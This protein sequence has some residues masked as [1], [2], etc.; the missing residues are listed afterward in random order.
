MDDDEGALRWASDD[1]LVFYSED[2][3]WGRL[4]A[5]RAT[6]GTP[7]PLTPANCMVA[8]SEAARNAAP[9]RP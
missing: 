3:N 7:R 1:T 5:I 4:Y 8:E 6:G 9:R 2:D